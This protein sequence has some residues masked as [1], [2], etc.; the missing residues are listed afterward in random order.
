MIVFRSCPRCSGDRVRESDAYGPYVMCLVCGHMEYPDSNR[1]VE[2]ARR[3]STAQR[4]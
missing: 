1:L 4:T 3:R 2:N